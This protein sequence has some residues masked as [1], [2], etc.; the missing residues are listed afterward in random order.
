MAAREKRVTFDALTVGDEVRSNRY[1]MLGKTL[2]VHLKPVRQAAR[3]MRGA[4]SDLS[5]P[6]LVHTFNR[7]MHRLL[8]IR[9]ESAESEADLEVRNLASCDALED[10]ESGAST[11]PV[12]LT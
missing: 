6:C 4:G 2:C 1:E 9:S 12:D 10:A 11:Q 7:S 8:L 3:R 5:I